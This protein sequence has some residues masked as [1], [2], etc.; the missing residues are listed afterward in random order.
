MDLQINNFLLSIFISKY[1]VNELCRKAR[2]SYRKQKNYTEDQYLTL[3][4]PG[5]T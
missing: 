1:R 3:F 2:S 4:A 5:N